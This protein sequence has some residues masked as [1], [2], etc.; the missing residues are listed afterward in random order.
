M[1]RGPML[2][3]WDVSVNK[4]TGLPFLGESA[5]V[6]FRVEI[7]NILNH[8]NFATPSGRIFTGALTDPA[9]ASEAPIP[10]VAKIQTTATSSRQIQLALKILF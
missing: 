2:S 5:K 1:L 3:T 8:A 6:Q 4:D 7:F 10:N 9:G